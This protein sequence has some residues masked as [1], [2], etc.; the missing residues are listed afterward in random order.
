MSLTKQAKILSAAQQ[1]TILTHLST[2][3]QARRNTVMFLLTV[4]SGLRAKEVAELTWSMITDGEGQ[5]TDR[6]C[7]ENSV[8]KGKSG[9]VI[10]MSNRLRRAIADHAAGGSM[11]DTVIKSQKGGPMTAQSVT[12]WYH[13]L[14]RKLGFEG[15]SGHSGRRTAITTWA[16]KIHGV[17]GSMRDVQ[18]LARH[19]SLQMTMRYI[20]ISEDACRKVVG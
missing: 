8:A 2:S 17:G 18:S 19:S 7:L 14:Y 11:A 13:Q 10:Y 16:R 20:E 12:N 1:N 5:L 15:C 3:R 9:G 4:D 6:I